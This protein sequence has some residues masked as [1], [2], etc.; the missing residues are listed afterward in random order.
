MGE[1][2][3]KEN[4]SKIPQTEDKLGRKL[5]SNQI[6]KIIQEK[7]VDLFDVNKFLE[8]KKQINKRIINTNLSI[9]NEKN[10]KN[11]ENPPY[12]APKEIKG[13]KPYI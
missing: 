6:E 12:S 3:R 11:K 8:F 2:R 7:Q 1:W 5:T 4:P 13:N 9:L 10:K